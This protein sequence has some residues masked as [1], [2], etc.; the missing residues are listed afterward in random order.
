M[1]TDPTP[2]SNAVGCGDL[3]RR[4][5]AARAMMAPHQKDR[6]QGKLI[7]DCCELV[8]GLLLSIDHL[9][10][11]LR[12]GATISFQDGEWWLFSKAGEGIKGSP[13]FEGLI[14]NIPPTDPA[15]A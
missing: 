1:S 13:T 5:F 15:N 6:Q 2:D 7:L 14:V 11:Y 8:G 3:V 4:L 12:D 9:E 10:R